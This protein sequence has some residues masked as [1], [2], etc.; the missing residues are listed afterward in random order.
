MEICVFL[1]AFYY[2]DDKFTLLDSQRRM[3]ASDI[4]YVNVA[5]KVEIHPTWK[6]K[7][8]NFQYIFEL[9][10]FN[11]RLSYFTKRGTCILEG[12]LEIL[13]LGSSFYSMKC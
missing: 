12:H 10:Y 4:K 9:D 13:Y 2:S 5:D 11:Y 8:C 3:L 7:N 1:L 6:L